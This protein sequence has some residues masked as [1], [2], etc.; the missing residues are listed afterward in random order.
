MTDGTWKIAANTHRVS[1]VP[2]WQ[3]R[4]PYIKPI[5]CSARRADSSA[6]PYFECIGLYRDSTRAVQSCRFGEFRS[7]QSNPIPVRHYTLLAATRMTL[8]NTTS[9]TGHIHNADR[10]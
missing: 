4:V 1:S 2:N 6:L 7:G 9:Q 10:I 5:T 8:H 3:Y